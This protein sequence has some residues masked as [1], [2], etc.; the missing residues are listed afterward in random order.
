MAY[1]YGK[2]LVGIALGDKKLLTG[3]DSGRED[4]WDSW[5]PSVPEDTATL[6]RYMSFAKFCS[7]LER[8]ELFFS[9]VT[10]M[11]DRCE[12]FIYP[13]TPREHGDPL[14]QAEHVGHELLGL[15][16][17]TAL[18]SCWTESVHESS[19]MWEVYA[20]SEGV[21]IRTTFQRLQESIRSVAELPIT[22]GRVGYV[23]YRRK[24]VPRFGF[25]PLFHKRVE[26][27]GEGEVRA[28]LPGPSFSERIEGRHLEAPDI[29]LDPD[30]AEQRGRY[31]PVNLE[32]LLKG[33]VLPPHAAPWFAQVVESVIHSSPVRAPVTRSSIESTPHHL[34]AASLIWGWR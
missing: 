22:F 10:E 4:S 29:P 26:Y 28:V 21:A 2:P 14:E 5:E 17:R 15:L 1:E 18:I 13:P 11:P 23:D 31:V 7:L 16:A 33:I 25:A 9:L 32:I 12:G 3:A 8:K 6:W 34:Q 19:L 24:E 27:L 20:G 30:V